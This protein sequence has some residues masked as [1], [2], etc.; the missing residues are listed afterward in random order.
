MVLQ[1]KVWCGINL[2]GGSY[3][4]RQV[5]SY[6]TLLIFLSQYNLFSF[7]FFSIQGNCWVVLSRYEEEQG[8]MDFQ[9]KMNSLCLGLAWI[10]FLDGGATLG[11]STT[12]AKLGSDKIKT[13]VNLGEA[14]QTYTGHVNNTIQFIYEF[15]FNSSSYGRV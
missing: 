2:G 6:F 8:L 10:L 11:F 15:T 13:V 1:S 4:R 9:F 5:L 3:K 7:Q 12:E 14:N